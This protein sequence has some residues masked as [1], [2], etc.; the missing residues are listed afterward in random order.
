MD[1]F[2]MSGEGL[3]KSFEHFRTWSGIHSHFID[4]GKESRQIALAELRKFAA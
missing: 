2:T 4:R 1:Q 3:S